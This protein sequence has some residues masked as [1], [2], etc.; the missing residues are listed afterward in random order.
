MDVSL[1]PVPLF[2][3]SVLLG[4]IADVHEQILQKPLKEA[5]PEVSSILQNEINRQKQS[6]VL[7]ASEV[8]SIASSG[9]YLG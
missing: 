7:I 6:I 5:D 2:S 4:S 8:L 1:P 9:G 3:L